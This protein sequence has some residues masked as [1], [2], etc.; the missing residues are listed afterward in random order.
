MTFEYFFEDLVIQCDKLQREVL[1]AS[2]KEI[3]E[4]FDE[5]YPTFIEEAKKNTMRL[6]EIRMLANEDHPDDE[7]YE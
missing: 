7:D 5:V 4:A 3:S 2:K 6:S 1:E